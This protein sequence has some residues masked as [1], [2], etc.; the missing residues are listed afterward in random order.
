MEGWMDPRTHLDVVER[1]KFLHLPDLNPD[2]PTVQSVATLYID[3]AIPAHI[4]MAVANLK[5]SESTAGLFKV[6][7]YT[8]VTHNVIYFHL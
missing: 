2:H 8:V 6:E 3:Y 1:E 5:A 4:Y 7:L